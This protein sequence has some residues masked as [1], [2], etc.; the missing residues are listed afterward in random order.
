MQNSSS[1]AAPWPHGFVAGSRFGPY[2]IESLV[3]QGGM[4]AVYRAWHTGLKR[5]EAL[6]LPLAGGAGAQSHNFA[7]RFLNEAQ[8]AAGLDHPNI[9]RV[10]GVGDE[11]ASPAYFAMEY[12]EGHDLHSLLERRVTLAPAEA[13]AIL[14]PV[15]RALDYAHDKGVFHRDVKPANIIL[16]GAENGPWQPK[17]VDFGI[18]RAIERAGRA[19]ATRLT[20][21]EHVVGT[22][23]YISP[24]IA[25]GAHAQIG[26]ASD[27]YSLGI[28]AYEMLCGAPPFVVAQGASKVSVLIKHVT[29]PPPPPLVAGV[30]LPRALSVALLSALEKDPAARPTS[31]VAF[32]E[33]LRA[34][35]APRAP[36]PWKPLA[37][38]GAFAAACL[39]LVAVSRG[40]PTPAP[41][42]VAPPVKAPVAVVAS[43]PDPRAQQR[44][45]AQK[46]ALQARRLVDEGVSGMLEL[47]QLLDDKSIEQAEALKQQDQILIRFRRALDLSRQATRSDANSQEGWL[48]M[49]RAKNYLGRCDATATIKIA[50][51]KFPGNSQ[52]AV[53]ESIVIQN[54]RDNKKAGLECSTD[55][56]LSGPI[57]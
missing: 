47:N 55:E 38:A 49:C 21:T 10:Y 18:A 26:P 6:K 4:A 32:V 16:Q 51:G 50:R 11:G 52:F 1:S 3:G 33:S 56:K 36:L 44:A 20:S 53:L 31:C 13:L 37:G 14:E 30:A 5:H 43:P 7:A 40:A 17:V 48:Q 2:Q 35:I 42:A 57:T 34:A 12:V 23:E 15:A 29:Q 54:V 19:D 27:L 28:V 25:S 41:L 8:L 45:Q 24:E 39:V 22:P 46:Q 9:A